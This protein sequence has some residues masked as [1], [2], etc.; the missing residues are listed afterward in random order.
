MLFDRFEGFEK[1]K[2]EKGT[3]WRVLV[4]ICVPIGSPRSAEQDKPKLMAEAIVGLA[5]EALAL[6]QLATSMG[7]DIHMYIYI[8]YMY[9]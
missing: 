9:I 2:K 6:R 4:L 7:K 1:L 5:K 8:Y 3:P